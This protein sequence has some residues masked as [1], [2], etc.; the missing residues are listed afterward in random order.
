MCR[1][2]PMLRNPIGCRHGNH[3]IEPQP[4]T[5]QALPRE[6]AKPDRHQGHLG[7]QAHHVVAGLYR[8]ADIGA[9][10]TECTQARNKPCARHRRQHENL[11]LP[12]HRRQSIQIECRVQGLQRIAQTLAQPLSGLIQGDLGAMAFKQG[13]AAPVFN[14][15]DVPADGAVG[16]MALC[17]CLVKLPKRAADSN[18]C[19]AGKEGRARVFIAGGEVRAGF[20]C[21]IYA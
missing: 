20:Y 1:Q 16:E 17:A 5:M 9:S 11:Q 2:L 10:H 21:A 7:R 15:L 6:L 19:R 13:F 4:V 12:L 3:V 14:G 8:Q 18:D